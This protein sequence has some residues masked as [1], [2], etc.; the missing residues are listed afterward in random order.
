MKQRSSGRVVLGKHGWQK[1]DP[2]S[3]P[4]VAPKTFER[5]L[6]VWLVLMLA[7]VALIFSFR[8]KE[9]VELA[10]APSVPVEARWGPSPF[11]AGLLSP[12]QATMRAVD[13]AEP[14][15][16]RLAAPF[17]SEWD[18]DFKS[19]RARFDELRWFG[20]DEVSLVQQAKV[21]QERLPDLLAQGTIGADDALLLKTDLLEV[22]ESDA[23]RRGEQL[24]AWWTEHPLPRPSESLAPYRRIEALR[25]E[26]SLVLEWQTQPSVDRDARDLEEQVRQLWA[27]YH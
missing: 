3:S 27:S 2:R 22:L 16:T 13:A 14:P 15:A 12:T 26:A 7:L 23:R 5:P 9:P 8:D 20:D 4:Q 11:E 21:A 25:R 24:V 18:L 10:Q 19:A 1:V 17:R 6:I